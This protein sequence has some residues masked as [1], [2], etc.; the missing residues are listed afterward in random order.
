M[1]RVPGGPTLRFYPLEISYLRP[2][3]IKLFVSEFA[4]EIEI[5]KGTKKLI[6]SVMTTD[7]QPRARISARPAYVNKRLAAR[8]HEAAQ[9]L[10]RLK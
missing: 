7:A 8:H 1:L 3:V 6:F 9:L 4:R 2:L 10:R 5:E